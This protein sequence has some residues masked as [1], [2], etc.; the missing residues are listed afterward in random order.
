MKQKIFF[1]SFLIFLIGHLPSSFA[2]SGI[3]ANVTSFSFGNVELNSVSD[4]QTVTLTNS[5]GG[6][7][8]VWTISITGEDPQQFE[9]VQDFCTDT[10]LSPGASCNLE[11][12]FAP[13]DTEGDFTATLAIPFNDPP[14]ILIPMS[15]TGKVPE[16]GGCNSIGQG[17]V[18]HS[19]L[20]YGF[21]LLGLYPIISWRRRV[22]QSEK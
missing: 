4:P 8:V 10:I 9:I 17:G 22:R 14:A 21:W 6:D 11:V 19:S 5:D 18:T 1:F 13:V 12:A 3:T 15:G 16:N 7:G 20:V 2:A